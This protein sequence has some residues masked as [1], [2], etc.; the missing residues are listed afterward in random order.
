M[1]SLLIIL[2]LS[3]LY[4]PDFDAA[5]TLEDIQNVRDTWAELMTPP[6]YSHLPDYLIEYCRGFN[7]PLHIAD[8][9]SFA[10]SS[11]RTDAVSHAAAY[12]RYQ[13]RRVWLDNYLW[14]KGFKPDAVQDTARFLTNDKNNCYIWAFSVAFW[15]RKGYDLPTIAQIWLYGQSGV[16]DGRWSTSYHYKIFGE[17][18]HPGNV[19]IL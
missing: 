14:I 15:R 17:G 8:A 6:D 13:I 9:W 7:I 2:L 5:F 1:R 3:A 11:H 19:S 12:G 10:E 4:A 18:E 16:Y